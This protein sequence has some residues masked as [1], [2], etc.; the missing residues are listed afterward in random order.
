MCEN[1]QDKPELPLIMPVIRAKVSHELH[2]A[3]HKWIKGK[4]ESEGPVA[5]CRSLLNKISKDNY[6]DISL[7]FITTCIKGEKD[8]KEI[9]YLVV[10]KAVNDPDYCVMYAHLCYKI[11]NH[12]KP[13]LPKLSDSFRTLLLD[14]CQVLYKI[15]YYRINIMLNLIKKN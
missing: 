9:I 1:F 5:H 8:L 2:S 14:E 13:T 3:E 4:G 12:C 15:L 11:I 7:D 6:Q 10:S